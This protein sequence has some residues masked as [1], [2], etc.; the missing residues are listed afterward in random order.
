[1]DDKGCMR[2][3]LALADK[4]RGMV[5]PNP[6]VGC[7]IVRDGGIVGRGY[8]RR[9]GAAHAEAA[10]IRDAGSAAR[11]ATM[12]VTLQ[13]CNHY[14]HTPPCTNAILKAGIR[15]LVYAADDCNPKSNCSDG[16]ARLRAGGIEVEG[17]IGRAE[18]LRQN[19]VYFMNRKHQRPFVA[20]K[21]AATLDAKIA[22]FQGRSQWITSEE[23]RAQV[24][25]LRGE[26][27]A[28]L[29]GERTVQTDDP[30]LTGRTPGRRNPIRVILDARRTRRPCRSR[31][32]SRR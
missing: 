3:A 26:Y 25:R 13:P 7:V 15:R 23:A 17:G 32:R 20:L 30:R 4:G 2:E 11:G 24:H 12:Y 1:M 19:E 16:L 10:A 9:Y 31:R 28:I 14:G 18:A 27:A 8:H 21:L 5:A 6:L 29:V 22:D